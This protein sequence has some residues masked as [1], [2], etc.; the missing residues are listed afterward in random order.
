MQSSLDSA[1]LRRA[2]ERSAASAQSAAILDREVEARM[3]ERLD[4][5]KLAPRRVLDA[6]SASAASIALLSR[7]Y[8]AAEFI[9]IDFAA[10]R[11]RGAGRG[12]S[13]RARLRSLLPGAPRLPLR[14]CADF[15]RA[16]LA[17][18]SVDLVWANLAL[19]YA[20]DPAAT[21]REWQ[22]VLAPGGLLMFSTYGP[23][24]LKELRVA[25]AGA[26]TYKHVH[27]FTDL[28]DLGDLL[29]ASGYADPVLDMEFLTLTYADAAAL[30]RELRA[31]G[32][33]NARDDRGRGL[34]S[35]RRWARMVAAYDALR[36]EGRIPAT[37][38]IV[39]GH[40]WK[41]QPR[42]A[43][44]DRAVVRFDPKRRAAPPRA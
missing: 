18:N 12:P 41:P 9:A 17:S 20:H 42:R 13:L 30:I 31:S 37:M 38:E 43:I 1:A 3:G 23:D 14:I 25:F 44:Q 24:T 16:P 4:Y 8:P 6:G 29:V 40:A 33:T 10:S 15:A 19:A 32:Q 22:R 27:D 35:P 36:V 26:D 21:L 28:H 5:V 39:Y 2:A 11:L 7:R 34:M